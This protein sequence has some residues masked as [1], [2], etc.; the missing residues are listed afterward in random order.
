MRTRSGQ[1]GRLQHTTKR[2]NEH[3]S[4]P[5]QNNECG[6]FIMTTNVMVMVMVMVTTT[7]SSAI[8]SPQYTHT[9]THTS[10]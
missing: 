2:T 5:T 6:E 7:E 10:K 9:H 4:R 8:V 3:T 1:C